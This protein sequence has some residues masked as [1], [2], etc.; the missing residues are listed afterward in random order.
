MLGTGTDT[1][2]IFMTHGHKSL[3]KPFGKGFT[4]A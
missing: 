2:V 3:P 1:A 4:Q